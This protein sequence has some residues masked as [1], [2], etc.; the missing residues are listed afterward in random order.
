VVDVH[1]RHI[2]YSFHSQYSAEKWTQL[3]LRPRKMG[4]ENHAFCHQIWE[5]KKITSLNA[6]LHYMVFLFSTEKILARYTC[7]IASFPAFRHLGMQSVF[8]KTQLQV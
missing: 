7:L 6:Y 4:N 1:I 5:R 2:N 3:S 8:I